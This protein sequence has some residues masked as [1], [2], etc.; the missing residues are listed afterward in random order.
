MSDITS[1]ASAEMEPTLRPEFTV[2]RSMAKRWSPQKS[3]RCRPATFVVSY[4]SIGV[5]DADEG[6]LLQGV[7]QVAQP[8]PV[9]GLSAPE[10]HASE[11]IAAKFRGRALDPLFI[12]LIFY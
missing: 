7:A 2:D 6:A 1:L 12:A 3:K 9:Q 11:G 5:A 10:E 8:R 4:Q